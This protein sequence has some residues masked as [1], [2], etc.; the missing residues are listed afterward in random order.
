MCRISYSGG[1]K[2]HFFGA[3]W[4]QKID[5]TQGNETWIIITHDTNDDPCKEYL[6]KEIAINLTGLMDAKNVEF[7]PIVYHI[8]NNSTNEVYTLE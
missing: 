4:N 7:A 8:I 5:T 2:A 1:C 3:V 6:T